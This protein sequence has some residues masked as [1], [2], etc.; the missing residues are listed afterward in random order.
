MMFVKM[1]TI[2]PNCGQEHNRSTKAKEPAAGEFPKDGD[3]SF[4]WKCGSI[5]IF[6]SDAEGGLRHPTESEQREIDNDNDVNEMLKSWRVKTGR[7]P[8]KLRNRN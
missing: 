4:C 1:I 2:C 7:L 8:W 5:N 6:E 3:C